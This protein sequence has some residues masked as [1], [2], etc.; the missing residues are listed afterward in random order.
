M[1]IHDDVEVRIESVPETG[2]NVPKMGKQQCDEM[3]LKMAKGWLP[4]SP[5]LR[6]R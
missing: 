4:K 3:V 1:R 5:R 2:T 6:I